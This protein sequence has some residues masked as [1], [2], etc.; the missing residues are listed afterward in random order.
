MSY[1]LIKKDELDVYLKELT[2]I[3]RKNNRK[4]DISYEIILVGGASILVNYSF[5]MSTS[6][7]DCIDVNNILMNDA[8]NVVAEKYSLPY[9]WINTDFKITKSYSDKLVN[10]ST[11]YKSFGNI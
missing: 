8:I 11:F 1:K 10:Y 7:V 9:D 5:R 3:I 2:K 4:N 6:D